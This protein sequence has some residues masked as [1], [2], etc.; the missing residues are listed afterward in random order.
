MT[1][2]AEQLQDALGTGIELE[3]EL[4]GGGMS[5]VFVAKDKALGRT[6]VVKVLPPDL[7]AGV[8]RERFR[9]E[10]QLAAQ[11]QHPHIVQLLSAGESGELLWYTM[12]YI[13]GESL[14]AAIERKKIF[15]VKEVARILHDVLDALAYAHKRGVVHRDIK[16]AN[17]LTQGSHAL[18]TDFGVAKALS[19]ALPGAG[20]GFTTAGMAIGTPSYM[21]PEQ[22]AGDPTADHRID[23]YAAGLLAYEL[24]SGQSPF[25]G[26]SPRE[27]MAA[28]L[29]R[30]PKP[31]HEVN[32]SVSASMSSLIMRLLAKDPD[33]RPATADAVLEELDGLTMPVGA[34]TP[35]SG[36]MAGVIAAPARSL[37]RVF[38]AIGVL[39]VVIVIA[40]FIM[41]PGSQIRA[42]RMARQQ[43]Q[44]DSVKQ[45]TD[46]LAKMAQLASQA[47]VLSHEDS[48]RIADNVNRAMR[49]QRVRDSVA[50][51]K[52]R[53]S[54][55][56]AEEKKTRDSIF[57][58]FGGTRPAP[59]KRRIVVLEPL[60][61]SRWPQAAQIGRVVADSLRSMLAKRAFTIVSPDSIRAVR[62]DS[63][64][65]EPAAWGNMFSSELVV[66]IRIEERP[67]RRGMTGPDSVRLRIAA[68]DLTAQPRYFAR[69][70]PQTS[71]WVVHEELLSNLEGT[72]LQ[73][74]GALEEMSRAP[75]RSAADTIRGATTT[76]TLPDGRQIS[77]P[78][79]VQVPNIG[80]EFRGR[81]RDGSAPATATPPATPKKPPV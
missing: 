71:D 53:D 76:I 35:K 2:F 19:A 43:A 42:Q 65:A 51:A 62:G 28:Q 12:P 1:S 8:N 64:T 40:A 25:A 66:S 3:R 78:V 50:R 75:R 30:D 16:P 37:T 61:S 49:Q 10:I 72:L 18:I 41:K 48:I 69:S 29:T 21:A 33:D 5:R 26:P 63:R 81:G 7:A 20:V 17:I 46:S 74:V 68:Y 9:R 52:V 59:A 6:I 22:L 11:L 24:L 39:A 79:G 80:M 73:T 27:T 55:Q 67:P 58:A 23:L 56:R 15:S 36:G 31:L 57:K 60:P 14:R 4:P 77:M 45:V 38:A 44:R 13:D 34:A 70:L 54:I 47:T 32:Q